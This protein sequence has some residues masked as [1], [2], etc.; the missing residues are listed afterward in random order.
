MAIS[1]TSAAQSR[2]ADPEPEG[3]HL[4]A[5]VLQPD[6][7]AVEPETQKWTGLA[8]SRAEPLDAY[9]SL[10]LLL[11]EYVFFFQADKRWREGERFGG[12]HS[13]C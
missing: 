1:G 13:V 4:A 6:G 12:V 11:H 9:H 10:R 7:V 2:R 3:E 5:S 8:L